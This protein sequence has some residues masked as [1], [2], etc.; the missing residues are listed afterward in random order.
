MDVWSVAGLACRYP[1]VP[2][3]FGPAT[4]H[5]VGISVAL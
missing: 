1:C 4:A 5:Y 3:W 2:A